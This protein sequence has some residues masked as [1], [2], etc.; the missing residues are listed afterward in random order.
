LATV[1]AGV[2]LFLR[3]VQLPVPALRTKPTASAS[4]PLPAE[5]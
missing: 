5:R 4:Y 1:A 2:G 3:E